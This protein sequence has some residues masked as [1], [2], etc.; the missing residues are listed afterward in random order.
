[1]FIFVVY[2]EM[3]I[4]DLMN[5]EI[6]DRRNA[7]VDFKI[8]CPN[9]D[10]VTFRGRPCELSSFSHVPQTRR[11]QSAERSIYNTKR[12][13][14]NPDANVTDYDRLFNVSIFRP[15]FS[16]VHKKIK[17]FFGT[18]FYLSSFIVSFK[19]NWFQNLAKKFT[20]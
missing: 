11:F 8:T 7:P 14:Q 12:N 3:N 2:E 15:C 16:F 1:M 6:E 18:N 19:I 10:I 5:E 4:E 20:S 17:M 9:N 13:S